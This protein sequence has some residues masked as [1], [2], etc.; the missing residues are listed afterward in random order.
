VFFDLF[1]QYII[2]YK[3]IEITNLGYVLP[4]G[5]LPLEFAFVLSIVVKL[6]IRLL[7]LREAKYQEGSPL[8]LDRPLETFA[9]YSYAK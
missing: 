4:K 6:K 5:L 2:Y 9:F 1:F 8:V 3:I 7:F